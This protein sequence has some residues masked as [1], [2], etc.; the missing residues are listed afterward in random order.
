M[1]PVIRNKKMSL[2]VILLAVT[3]EA[4]TILKIAEY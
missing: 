2:R 1:I 4:M 3:N